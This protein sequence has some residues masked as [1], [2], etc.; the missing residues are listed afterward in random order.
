MKPFDKLTAFRAQGQAKATAKRAYYDKVEAAKA[1]LTAAQIEADEI[2]A[3]AISAGT[4]KSA[5][6]AVAQAKI[7]Q[8]EKD[9]QIAQETAAKASQ[10]IDAQPDEIKAVDVVEAYMSDYVPSVQ[11]EHMPSIKAR[12]KQG[13]DLILS[14]YHDFHKLQR[15]YRGLANEVN[16]LDE[17]A[18][19]MGQKSSVY[20]LTNP[21]GNPDATRFNIHKFEGKLTVAKGYKLPEDVEY[22]KN[23]FVT[24][25]GN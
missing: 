2:M 4:D 3:L 12:M 25:E 22:H 11:A 9:V 7:E 14:A 24:K 17:H 1:A 15:E 19:K 10:H 20:S 6:Q 23:P 16:S 18:N 8:A 5:E 13:Q 21:F